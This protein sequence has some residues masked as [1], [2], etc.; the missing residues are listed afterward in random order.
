MNRLKYFEEKIGNI[1]NQI[2]EINYKMN[3]IG[4][5]M[6]KN[7]S[8]YANLEKSAVE[9]RNSL[10]VL[11]WIAKASAICFVLYIFYNFLRV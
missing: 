1:D 9:I 2:K 5:M 10:A 4:D 7:S 3:L 8:T 6:S 11:V